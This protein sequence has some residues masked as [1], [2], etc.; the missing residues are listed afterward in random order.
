MAEP[1]QPAGIQQALSEQLLD[2]SK[3]LRTE[4]KQLQAEAEWLLQQLEQTKKLLRQE[5]LW[6]TKQ[7]P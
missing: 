3:R 5:P 1:N 2:E 6:P 7:P 4:S